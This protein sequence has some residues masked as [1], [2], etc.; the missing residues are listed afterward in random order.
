MLKLY[1]IAVLA[2]LPLPA[3]AYLDPASGNALVYL[4]VSLF[5]AA[6]YFVKSAFYRTVAF[7]KG[8]KY[9][10]TEDLADIV[11]FSEGKSY[12]LSYKPIIEAL[13]EKKI[14]FRY[15]TME[16]TDPAL[17][18][19]NEFMHSKYVGEG[20]AGFARVARTKAPVM[21]TTTPNIGCPGFPLPRPAGVK[22]LVHFWHSVCDT[23]FYQLGALDHYDTALTVGSW[24][25]SSIRE[26]EKIR[27][28]PVKTVVPVG[29]PYL[30]E[31]AQKIT[32]R[33]KSDTVKTILIAPSWGEKNCLKVYG[34]DFIE[35][36]AEQ[37]YRII[38]RPHP[39][40]LKVEK[41]FALQVQKL[42]EKYPNCKLDISADGSDSMRQADLLVSDKSSIRFDFA[43]LYERPVVT[44][45][46]PLKNLEIYEASLLGKLWEED[47]A[48]KIGMR[49]SVSEK[50]KIAETVKCALTIVP[51]HIAQIREKTIENFG[52]SG[53]AIADWLNQ[54]TLQNLQKNK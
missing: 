25:E 44:L 14:H 28:I 45:D 32:P 17:M 34:T 47:Q 8:E 51:A 4:A 9:V 27:R 12:W 41:A 13:I 24:V 2:A 31:L 15:L 3:F 40:S 26:I 37:G 10:R 42:L 54:T 43:F 30:D 49:L 46:I 11:I 1:W 22:Q 7:F 19:D 53:R 18:I 36:L 20:A 50:N 52:S 35:E 16:V 38:V 48:E 21:L 33:D 23:G 39:Q 29:L 6:A 5:G